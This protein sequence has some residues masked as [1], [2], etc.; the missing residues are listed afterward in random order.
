MLC[1]VFFCLM[2]R[3]PP[4]ST[5]SSSSAAS[6]VYKRQ[7]QD[8]AIRN[9][10]STKTQSIFPS[11]TLIIFG[12]TYFVL[13]VLTYGVVFPSGL[14][15]PCILIGASYGRLTGTFVLDRIHTQSET[16]IDEATYALL[17]AA[18]CLGGAMRMTVSLVVILVELTNNVSYLPLLMMV[19]LVAKGVGD[20]FG[21]GIY[22]RHVDLKG[23]PF[24]GEQPVHSTR[25]LR[26]HD[27]MSKQ[28][29]QFAA[30]EKIG[31]I[32][33]TLHNTLHNGFPVYANSPDDPQAGALIG[34]VLR[35]QLLVLLQGRNFQCTPTPDDA[36]YE[37]D[38]SDVKA[39]EISPKSVEDIE[40]TSEE[41]RMYLDLTPYVNSSPYAVPES[42][43]LSKAY[44]LFRSLGLLPL[45]VFLHFYNVTFLLPL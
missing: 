41:Q 40:L 33:A 45:V 9:F 38:M 19:L 16:G 6:D 5:L 24:L 1:I 10:F 15:I 21:K 20:L 36:R 31:T 27:V 11:S 13:A 34:T 12:L 18:S 8:D 25:H 23:M 44:D 3:R 4:R 17:G 42:C 37:L 26:A 22:D 29:C 35:A 14:F 7:T 2:I 28:V 43:S 32:L 30:V 39:M